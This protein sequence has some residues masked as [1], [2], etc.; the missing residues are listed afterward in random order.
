[1]HTYRN[2]KNGSTFTTP[3]VCAGEDY[4]EVKAPASPTPKAKG[5]KKQEPAAD[6]QSDDSGGEDS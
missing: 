6:T 3:C 1:M 5:G 4:E 2:K